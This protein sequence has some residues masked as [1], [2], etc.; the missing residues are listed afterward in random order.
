MAGEALQTVYDE[1]GTGIHLA[2]CQQCG[3]MRDAIATLT[4]VLPQARAE[5]AQ[6]LAREAV[7][8]ARKMKQVH[9]D[10]LGCAHCYPAEAQN[11]LALAFPT[12]AA[13]LSPGCGIQVI[14]NTWPPVVGEY[15]VLDASAP[16]AVSTLASL[17]LSG[18][19]AAA[20]PDGLAIVAKTE[21][22]NIGIDK[23]IKN[24][25]ANP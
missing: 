12:I 15:T 7:Q 5:G 10:C 21:T 4:T 23:L 3:C 25:I 19:L 13:T 17:T 20:R 2:K 8:W 14:A 1:I 6:E 24:T 22:E 18:Q 9:Y 16:V 11:S